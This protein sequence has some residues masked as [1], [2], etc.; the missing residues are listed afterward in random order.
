[1]DRVENTVYCRTPVVSVGTFLFVNALLSNGCVFSFVIL[2]G[3]R[4]SPLA[5]AATIVLLYQPQMMV[6]VEQ[7]VE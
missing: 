1:M 4:L 7:L 6:I 3:V 5:T 2:S